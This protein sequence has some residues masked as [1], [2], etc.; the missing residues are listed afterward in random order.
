MIFLKT[1]LLQAINEH[2]Q[3]MHVDARLKK[4]EMGT[5]IDWSTAEALAF[6]SILLQG[7]FSQWLEL[8]SKGVY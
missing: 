2:L 8:Y 1:F 3:K 4:M 5:N 7:N 6:G